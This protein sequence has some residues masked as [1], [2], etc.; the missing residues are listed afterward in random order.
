MKMR[1][2]YVI[3][4]VF[5]ILGALAAITQFVVAICSLEFGRVVFYFV[6]TALLTELAVLSIQKLRKDNKAE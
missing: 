3:L 4:S 1:A 5:G 2:V 6:V